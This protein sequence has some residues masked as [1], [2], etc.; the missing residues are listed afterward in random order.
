MLHLETL[1]TD[2][3]AKLNRF[4]NLFTDFL[5]TKSAHCCKLVACLSCAASID[6]TA[7]LTLCWSF[8][9]VYQEWQS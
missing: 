3:A 6:L 9:Q 5:Q 2:L 1:V 4:A 7:M 8:Y